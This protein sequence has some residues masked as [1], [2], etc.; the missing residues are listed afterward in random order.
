M[1]KSDL[2]SSD[3]ADKLELGE[4]VVVAPRKEFKS[5]VWKNFMVI[6]S[7]TTGHYCGSVHCMNCKSVLKHNK[8]TSGTTHLSVHLQRC[9]KRAALVSKQPQIS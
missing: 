2:T 9:T 1:K 4:A 8:A 5:T 7:S 6:N 3:S